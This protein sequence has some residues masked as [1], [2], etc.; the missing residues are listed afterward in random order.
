ME[1]VIARIK[2]LVLRYMP[3]ILADLNIT[4]D[5]LDLYVEDIVDRILDYTNRR[6]LVVKYEED[7]ETYSSDD[8]IWDYYDFPIPPS[9]EKVGARVVIDAI[10][11]VENRLQSDTKEIKKIK[12]QG[13]EVEY[14][15]ELTNYFNSSNDAEVF[16][17]S[18]TL[19]DRYKLGTVLGSTKSVYPTR[20]L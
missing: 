20:P 5:Q 8:D 4:N 17:G 7:L 10:R 18:L 9:L 6:Q 2:A 19:L 1:D 12:D 14:G 3:T 11:T 16:T 13:Q 15:T